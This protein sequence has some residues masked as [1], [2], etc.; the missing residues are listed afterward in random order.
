M[1]HNTDHDTALIDAA[2]ASVDDISE[3]DENYD[4]DDENVPPINNGIVNEMA[5]IAEHGGVEDKYLNQIF[6]R[7]HNALNIAALRASNIF[8]KLYGI[9]PKKYVTIQGKKYEKRGYIRCKGY[10]KYLCKCSIGYT[11]INN[12]EKS[13]LNYVPPA[14]PIPD[15]GYTPMC[16]SHQFEETFKE[17]SRSPYRTRLCVH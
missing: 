9:N 14:D 15:G 5:A 17:S 3:G 11:L 6:L 13:G 4:G 8:T 2:S 12:Y 7:E 1:A 16:C 10:G